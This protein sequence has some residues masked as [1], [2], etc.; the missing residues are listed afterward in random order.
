MPVL[1]APR[2]VVSDVQ[3]EVLERVARSSV[4]PHRKVVQARGLLLAADGVA[5]GEI[6]RQCGVSPDAVRRW[7]ARFAEQGVDGVGMIAAGRGRKSWLPDGV[8]VAEI[9]RVTL[10]ETPGDTS[11]HWSTRTLAERMG[12]GKDTVARVWRDHGVKPLASDDIQVVERSAVRGETRRC[13]WVVP[14]PT[15]ES[16]GVRFRR[17]TPGPS[18]GPHPSFAPNETRASRH[19]DFDVKRNGTIVLFAAMNVAYRA[20]V[21]GLPERSHQR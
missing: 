21:D 20:G 1:I 2:L 14:E 18:I 3:R 13:R 6:A 7:R 4:E 9:I 10:E 8:T 19:D 11:T 16:D 15:G 17:E 5:N 12:V